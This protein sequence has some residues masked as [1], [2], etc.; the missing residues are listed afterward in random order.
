M[1]SKIAAIK[2]LQ[3]RV[4]HHAHLLPKRRPCSSLSWS[5]MLRQEL[6]TSRRTH[7]SRGSIKEAGTVCRSLHLLFGICWA[8]DIGA[9]PTVH[10]LLWEC[11]CGLEMTRK[12]HRVPPTFWM[13]GLSWLLGLTCSA[14]CY[15][16]GTMYVKLDCKAATARFFPFRQRPNSDT[17]HANPP[18]TALYT[19][20]KNNRTGMVSG[21][22]GELWER[23]CTSTRSRIRQP[24]YEPI[25]PQT[26]QQ[27]PIHIPRHHAIL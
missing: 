2:E 11:R 1:S 20:G 12:K 19:E 24:S 27:R 23:S 4:R 9:H 3:A 21:T 26:T 15:H 5:I 7:N 18:R 8:Y 10:H 6:P 14:C 22:R 13:T 25:R 16:C 17:N